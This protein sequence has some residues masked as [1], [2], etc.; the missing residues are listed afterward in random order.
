M[1]ASVRA[2]PSADRT[3]RAQR[4]LVVTPPEQSPPDLVTADE[5]FARCRLPV[6]LYDSELRAVRASA[7]AVRELGLSEE[8]MRGRRVTDILPP[9]LCHR[10]EDGMGRV[11]ATGAA[12]QFHVRG[13]TRPDG[14]EKVWSVTAYPPTTP[15]GQ[16]R[17]P[18]VSALDVTEQHLARER[19]AL[20]NDVSA[21]VGTPWT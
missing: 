3:G 21:R 14:P 12:E 18:E 9:H 4:L 11:L 2:C 13:R 15:A 8:R 17:H 10:V 16:V 20:L 7:G 1:H 6:L 5:V 19:L